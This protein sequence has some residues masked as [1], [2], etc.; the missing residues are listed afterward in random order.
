MGG[1]AI[2]I[3]NLL[4]IIYL[5]PSFKQVFKQLFATEAPEADGEFGKPHW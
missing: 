3:Y 1:R 5:E 2:A 4:I